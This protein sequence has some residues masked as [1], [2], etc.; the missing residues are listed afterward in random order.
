MNQIRTI[1][2]ALIVLT[3][4]A[5]GTVPAAAQDGPALR[6]VATTSLIADVAENI[7]GDR[8]AVETLIPR[9]VDAHDFEPTTGDIIAIAEADVVL[10]NGLFLEEGLLVA[11]EENADNDPVVVSL[12]VTVLSGAHHHGEEVIEEEEDDEEVR[13][14]GVLG[15]DDFTCEGFEDEEEA[16]AEEEEPT[17]CDPHVWTDPANVIIWTRNIAAAF[18][19]SDPD[20]ADTYA[21]NAAVYIA[22]LETLQGEIADM[23][24]TVPEADR[25]LVTNHAFLGYFA[26]AY[27][28]E[29]IG[30]VIPSVSTLA[31]VTATGIIALVETI[32]ETGVTAIFAE[33][34]D[35]TGLA[36]T[37][38]NEVGYDVAIVALYSE[39]LSD[40]DG[41]AATYLDYM[42]ANTT[43]IV[44]A[45][46]G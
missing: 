41:P 15:E 46:T 8:V 23:V 11:I 20:N 1:L 13:V 38:A 17:I 16:E 2:L 25:L 12:G 10:V 5:I 19:A 4:L 30:T 36:E 26:H 24:E 33:V 43:A 42:R 31:E 37:V 27:G 34:S 39:S 29:V 45:L 32:R 40:E 9:G 6:V 22:E 3:L 18:S 28:F 14:L 44:D 21:A 7:G 35:T